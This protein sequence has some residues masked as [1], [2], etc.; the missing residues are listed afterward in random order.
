VADQTQ[1]GGGAGAEQDPWAPPERKTS[2]DKG[3]SSAPGT[4]PAPQDRPP[5][6]HDQATVTSFPPDGFGPPA[7]GTPG[8]STPG[9]GA[10]VQ[11]T[12][13]S[14]FAA[15]G[16][17]AS[18]HGTPAQGTPGFGAPSYAPPGTPGVTN[19]WAESAVPPPPVA[20]GAGA[21]PQG[22]GG[23]YGYPAYPQGYGWPGMQAPPQNGMGTAAMVLGILSCCLFCLYG[24]VGL[25]LGVLAVVFGVKGKRRADR[26]EATNRGQAQAGFI[27][28][29]IGIIL[30]L[31]TIAVLIVGIALAINDEKNRTDDEPSYNSAPSISAPLLTQ[32]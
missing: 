21:G 32:A 19:G 13:G 17:D 12:P 16:Q 29:I 28:G 5:S 20:P 25:T 26:G 27:T 6:V 23:G 7:Q 1:P 31:A 9:F 3:T 11:P 18:G 24:I 30:G 22:P 4:Q 2:L 8:Q 10:P 15:P 14:G